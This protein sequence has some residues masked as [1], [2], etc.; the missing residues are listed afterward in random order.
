MLKYPSDIVEVRY[1]NIYNEKVKND[2]VIA[3]IS[4][5]HI[6]D[7]IS[8]REL[9]FIIETIMSQ[10]PN[11]ICILG[12]LLD[13][14]EIIYDY[15]NKYKC[16][17]FLK[18]IAKIAPVYITIGNHDYI[19]YIDNKYMED[20]NTIFWYFVN[21]LEN[22]NVLK[23]RIIYNDDITMMGY[24]G[25]YNIYHQRNLSCFYNDLSKRENLYKINTNTP[26]VALIHSPEPLKYLNNI[27][28]L[29][30]YDLIICGHYHNGC[31]PSFLNKIIPKEKGL[32]TPSKEIFPKN[33]RGIKLLSS[34]TYLIN[35]GGWTKMAKNTPNYLHF[36]DKICNRN[37]DVTT[38]TNNKENEK[39]YTKKISK[40]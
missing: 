34:G 40:N 35:N 28:L 1:S 15:Y 17:Y 19:H 21:E 6:S 8:L 31:V 4:D 39:I 26:S 38:I 22:V 33:A 36:L 37:I 29:K 5:V 30:S 2:I 24:M 25:K 10:N 23:D 18:Q 11:Y 14:P 20:Y 9:D 27:N 3:S 7:D 13:S 12:D 16:I 32:V